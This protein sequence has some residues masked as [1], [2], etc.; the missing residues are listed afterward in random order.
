MIPQLFALFLF[1]F[2]YTSFQC[3]SIH[4]AATEQC[5]MMEIY[6]TANSFPW[7]LKQKSFVI[8]VGSCQ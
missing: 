2:P 7:I 4:K 5:V 1:G 8:D 6:N 3:T